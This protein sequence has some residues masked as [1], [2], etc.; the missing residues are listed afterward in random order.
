MSAGRLSRMKA[1]TSSRNA[2]SSGVKRRSI[3]CPSLL[4][5]SDFG[6]RGQ[7]KEGRS[8]LLQQTLDVVQFHLRP[9]AVGATMTQFLLDRLGALPLPLL[10]YRD[11]GA[12]ISAGA[13]LAIA[14][15]EW[16]AA[17]LR[18]ARWWALAVAIALIVALTVV[19]RQP[20]RAIAIAF[21]LA[22][23]LAVLLAELLGHRLAHLTTTLLQRLDC[24]L[25]CFAG[26]GVVAFR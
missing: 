22:A 15:S 16:V 20:H 17:G 11:V 24:L 3:R 13:P 26:P 19:Q 6:S 9:L 23:I 25:L 21:L 5:G 18:A 2:T 4:A 10:G 7:R 1:R 14:P 8:E 12:L